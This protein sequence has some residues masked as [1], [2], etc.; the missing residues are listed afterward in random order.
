MLKGIL[1]CMS[2]NFLFGLGYYF[3]ILLRPL[4]GESMFGFRIVVLA[5]FILLAILL[6]KQTAKFQ[7]LWQ[8]SS[9]IHRLSWCCYCLL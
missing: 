5:P 1:C 2:A 7:Q 6:F 9:K 3:A 4:N 8:K